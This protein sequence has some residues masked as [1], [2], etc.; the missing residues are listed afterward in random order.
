MSIPTRAPRDP[1]DPRTTRRR[2]G[3]RAESLVAGQ[4]AAL[5]WTVLAAGVRVGRDELDLVAIEPGL[6]P[7]LVFVEV[8]SRSDSRFG[9]PEETI[10]S[11]KLARTYRAAFSLLRERRLPDGRPLPP[12]RWRV[13][14]VCV[15]ARPPRPEDLTAIE[16]R[17]VRGIAPD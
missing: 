9:A 5:G 17:H 2:L 3:D 1:A 10:D 16:V 12:L 7:T 13:D 14:L 4:L 8:R 6:P 11:A 15:D